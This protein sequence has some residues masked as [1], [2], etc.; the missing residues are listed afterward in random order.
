MPA[1]G[2]T[3]QGYEGHYFWDTEI[4]VLPFLI[5]TTPR[6]A[7]NLL[8]FRHSY[9]EKAL[10]RAAEVNQKGALF[11][12]RTINGDEAFASYAAGTAQ[13]HINADIIYALKK[14]V[15]AT[16]D[17]EFLT[18]VGAEVLVKTAR[19]WFDLGFFS[20]RKGGRFVINGVTGPDEHNTVVD[21]NCHTNL[22]AWENLRYAA[23]TVR[24]LI[25]EDPR[26]FV[27]LAAKT[28]VNPDEID[29]WHR[30]ADE[31]YVPYDEERWIHLQ[32]ARVGARLL[33]AR[34]ASAS[35]S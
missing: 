13:Y 17:T 35:L 1:K 11:P 28:G 19:L 8:R 21:N 10:A 22:M 16:G 3:G 12:W 31:M 33:R 2:L 14:Y 20:P 30:A 15:D 5:Y 9:I 18:E 27:Y 25:D 4:Y 32:D 6:I 26:Q 7:K 24:A 29:D 23:K 34:S